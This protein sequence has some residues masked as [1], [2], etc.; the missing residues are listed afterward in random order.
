M[1]RI[2]LIWKC[3]DL[4]KQAVRRCQCGLF[5]EILESNQSVDVEYN[6]FNPQWERSLVAVMHKQ[7]FLC[8]VHLSSEGVLK[9]LALLTPLARELVLNE[10]GNGRKGTSR[11]CDHLRSAPDQIPRECV[12]D[13]F[14]CLH[15]IFRC[16]ASPPLNSSWRWAGGSFVLLNDSCHNDKKHRK[17]NK[18]LYL[19]DDS[20]FYRF[21]YKHMARTCKKTPSQK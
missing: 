5:S 4:P 13:A 15:L 7:F 21:I 8:K 2:F 20:I 9:G 1:Q 6:P 11:F 14:T 17:I 16:T 10:N 3:F 18:R 19:S 12:T